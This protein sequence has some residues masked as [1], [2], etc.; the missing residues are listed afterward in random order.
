MISVS[1]VLI[2]DSLNHTKLKA[3]SACVKTANVI[4]SNGSLNGDYSNGHDAYGPL[5]NGINANQSSLQSIQQQ[6]Q[7]VSLPFPRLAAENVLFTGQTTEG[8]IFLTNF[9]LF[10]SFSNSKEGGIPISLPVGIIETV[11]CRDL[12]YLYVYTKHVR[13]IIC[14]FS[15]AEECTIWHK[16]LLDICLLQNKFE[17]LFC[18]KFFN[19]SK[20]DTNNGFPHNILVNTCHDPRNILWKEATRMG[21][22]SSNTWRMSDINKDFKLCISYPPILIVPHNINDKDLESVANF[23]Y[24]RRIPTAVWRHQKNGCIIARSSQPEVG[25]LGWRNNQDE[26]LLQSLVTACNNNE[27][28][29]RKLLVLDAR[30]YAAAVA[31]RAKGGGCECPE[32]Y[33]N[34][35]VQFMSLANIHSI[36]KSFHCLRYICESPADQFK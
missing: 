22:E 12:F 18:F 16:R 26:H 35:E 25:W 24:S 30:S 1:E 34:C 7:Q 5:V 2:G 4:T 6:Q 11:E 19:A 27:S 23:R 9:R 20:S 3:S 33:S 17:G 15:S 8:V 32:Y 31:N 10:L 28:N 14:S 13:S 36:R 21:F 29:N